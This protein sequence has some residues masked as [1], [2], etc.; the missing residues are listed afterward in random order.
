MRH[1]LFLRALLALCLAFRLCRG[2]PLPENVSASKRLRR[3]ERGGEAAVASGLKSGR[4]RREV[5][6]EASLSVQKG[7][8]AARGGRAEPAASLSSSLSEEEDADAFEAPGPMERLLNNFLNCPAVDRFNAAVV[9]FLGS[10]RDG[11]EKF[12]IRQANSVGIGLG[13]LYHALRQ[14]PNREARRA[15]MRS[16]KAAPAVR[17]FSRRF[18]D[19]VCSD[20]SVRSSLDAL[21]G[22][23]SDIA[24]LALRGI[25]PQ[26]RRDFVVLLSHFRREY[27]HILGF[28][29]L[30]L[31]QLPHSL[32]ALALFVERVMTPLQETLKSVA[33]FAGR[34]SGSRA[35]IARQ[36]LLFWIHHLSALDRAIVQVVPG[37]RESLDWTEASVTTVEETESS[38]GGR[39]EEVDA[40]LTL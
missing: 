34:F 32:N 33:G 17:A 12:I 37:A 6:A 18:G 27:F 22:F 24:R 29:A 3:S 8:A 5:E 16:V 10:P 20:H 23:R 9:Y 31:R 2:K 15:L 7:G 36:Q 25:G 35:G 30:T 19:C 4:G 13:A 26:E 1:V 28:V 40:L 11:A 21:L 39:E 38:Y 14:M